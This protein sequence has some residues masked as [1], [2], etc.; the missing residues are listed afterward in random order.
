LTR[1]RLQIQITN[2]GEAVPMKVNFLKGDPG[3]ILVGVEVPLSNKI[4][5][6]QKI[7]FSVGKLLL[8]PSYHLH[9]GE[10]VDPSSSSIMSF[11]IVPELIY[12]DFKGSWREPYSRLFDFLKENK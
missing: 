12:C 8:N 3:D 9:I 4:S 1:K 10:L 11:T 7:V 6:K 5:S 2:E